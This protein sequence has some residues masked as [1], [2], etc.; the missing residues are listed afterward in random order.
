M[1]GRY[2]KGSL[3]SPGSAN[4]PSAVLGPNRSDPASAYRHGYFESARA[5]ARGGNRIPPDTALYPSV[6]LFRHAVELSLKQLI[7]DMFLVAGKTP[8]K[9]NREHRLSVL[10]GFLK[11]D[12][13][14][15]ID[16]Q[17]PATGEAVPDSG[18]IDDLISDLAALD[19]DGVPFRY[20][21]TPKGEDCHPA[22]STV[23]LTALEQGMLLGEAALRAWMNRLEEEAR[24]VRERIA[25]RA[26]LK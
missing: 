14:A 1:E 8:P 9:I 15:W 24:F 20:P 25:A 3:F 19:P 23:D 7:A 2:R 22:L 21:T 26:R 4:R 16:L 12:L 17:R 18:E 5:L 6:F 11:P 13:D 10:W